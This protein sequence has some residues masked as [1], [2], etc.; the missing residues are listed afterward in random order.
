MKSNAEERERLVQELWK[1][2]K[3]GAKTQPASREE[4]QEYHCDSFGDE[5]DF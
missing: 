4:H 1:A 5:M 3:K 2:Q